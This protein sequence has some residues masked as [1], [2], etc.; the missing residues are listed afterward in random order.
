M[1]KSSSDKFSK[2]G[3]PTQRQLR[4]G[5]EI[6][7]ALADILIRQ[8]CPMPELRGTSITVSEVRI[9]PNLRHANAYVTPLGGGDVDRVVAVLN[10]YAGEFRHLVTSKVHVKYSPTLRFKPDK[11]FEE[12]KKI[13][14]ILH[15]PH[16]RQDLEK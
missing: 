13:T 2:T 11:S 5:E 9:T 4:V 6:R 8:D 15:S 16:V 1:P 3:E 12:A 7:H 10:T 14:D